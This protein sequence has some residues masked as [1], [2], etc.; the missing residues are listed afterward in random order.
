MTA[1][2]S[3]VY[4][5]DFAPNDYDDDHLTP[6]QKRAFVHLLSKYIRCVSVCVSVSEHEWS[7]LEK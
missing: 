2:E 1:D 7:A 4:E 3:S 6:K 5:S